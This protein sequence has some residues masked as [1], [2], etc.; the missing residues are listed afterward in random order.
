MDLSVALQLLDSTLVLSPPAA[1]LAFVRRH[2]SSLRWTGRHYL[3]RC[4]ATRAEL[5]CQVLASL[6]S[7]PPPVD[8][9]ILVSDEDA[10]G[11][12]VPCHLCNKL[13][14]CRRTLAVHLAR[15]H[16]VDA[17]ATQVA[18]GTRCEVC[19]MEFWATDR[20]RVHLRKSRSC[21]LVYDHGDQERDPGTEV[22]DRLAHA[23]RP[24]IRTAG[25]RPWWAQL[26]PG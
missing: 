6:V 26:C 19:G 7:P 4:R 15:R 1:V 21:L 11:L 22:L 24:A 20:L 9:P 17:A 5:R 3:R 16:G 2:C 25:P 10:V 12:G 13:L 14:P 23:S 8:A 18:H